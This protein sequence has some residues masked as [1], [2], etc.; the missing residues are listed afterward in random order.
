MISKHKIS[1]LFSVCTIVL[2]GCF[3][4]T[5]IYKKEYLKNDSTFV[6]R[7]VGAEVLIGL[8]NG[9]EHTGEL[10]SA[11]DSTIIL[12]K[13]YELSE[14]ELLSS[15]SNIYMFQKK[16]IKSIWILGKDYHLI[17]LGIG[18][19][20]GI[21]LIIGSQP[22]KGE[23]FGNL[24]IAGLGLMSIAAGF[25]VGAATSTY[26]EEIYK[27]KNAEDPDFIQLNVYSRYGG[28]EP[29]YLKAMK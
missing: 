16:D 14:E 21:P 6:Q 27:N 24:E 19:G 22:E 29:E 2:T 1:L 15:V 5:K 13:E 23:H 7:N 26:D 9:D 4:S 28:K 20:I 8:N 12:S 10:L 25:I 11:T 3:S 18:L 17:G